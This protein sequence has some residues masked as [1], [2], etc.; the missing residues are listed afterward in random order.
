[1][2]TP[3]KT[4]K[5]KHQG[6]ALIMAMVFI[7]IFSAISIG[8]LSLSS[9]NTQPIIASATL[10]S[11]RRYPVWTAQ[12]MSQLKPTMRTSPFPLKPEATPFPAQILT[13]CGAIYIVK[14]T[15]SYRVPTT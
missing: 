5:K 1:M 15:P 13:R 10:P 6:I 8:F 3:V 11:M 4:I 12:S 14:S 2:K 7:I 9:A